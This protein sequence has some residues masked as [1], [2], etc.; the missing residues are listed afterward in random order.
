M[1]CQKLIKILRKEINSIYKKSNRED[2]CNSRQNNNK[3]LE[4]TK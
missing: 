3:K 1:K 4:K 2:Y